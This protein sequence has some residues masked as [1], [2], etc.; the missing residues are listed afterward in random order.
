MWMLEKCF[1]MCHFLGAHCFSF[2]QERH[3]WKATTSS[4][5]EKKKFRLFVDTHTEIS[6]LEKCSTLCRIA[7]A[8][9]FPFSARKPFLES[10]RQQLS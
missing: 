7:T 10:P 5:D 2:L 8:K 4:Y 6:R 3:F 9:G 1:P